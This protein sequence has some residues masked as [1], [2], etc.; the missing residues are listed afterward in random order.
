[1]SYD[2]LC[3]VCHARPKMDR[4]RLCE[5]CWYEPDRCYRARADVLA[6]PEMAAQLFEL[7][8]GAYFALGEDA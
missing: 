1:M 6:C 3:T 4:S 8:D 5:E 7:D 2:P